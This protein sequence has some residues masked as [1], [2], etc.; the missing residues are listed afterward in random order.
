ME[1]V[2]HHAEIALKG[3]NR[4]FFEKKLC[5]NLEG[6]AKRKNLSCKARRDQ[7]RIRCS[8]D[9]KE[10]D[11]DAVFGKTFG[12]K[13][14]AVATRIERTEEA[15]LEEAQRRMKASEAKTVRFVTKRADKSF[16]LTSLDIN[17][18]LGEV[19]NKHAKK[20]DYSA[21]EYTLRTEVTKDAIYVY[22][23]KR[24]G[25]GGLPV[26]TAGKVLVLFSGGIDSA[27]AAYLAM[28]RGC[29]CDFLHLHA[30]RNNDDVLKTK[31]PRII[32]ALNDYQPRAVLHLSPYHEYQ[33]RTIGAIPQPLDLVAFKHLVLRIGQGLARKHGYKALV[34]GDSIGQ[35]ASQTLDNL[36]TQRYG[37]T[38]PILSPLITY[39]K[40]EIIDLTK[41]AGT[42]ELSIEEYKD[43][44]S[45]VS[46]K[47]D[48]HAKP[49][50]L[51]EALEK[52]GFE[53]VVKATVDATTSSSIPQTARP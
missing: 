33:L 10:S 20:V 2:V 32:E 47:P 49:E 28:K 38:A 19:A 31:I 25:L 37:I 52:S 5:E 8:F 9:G 14:Y 1:V 6:A 29:R 24:P 26:G 34:T 4:G 39:D 41:R 3:G 45:I 27:A 35:V 44:C 48:T 16:P 42:Y 22:D 17:K 40:Q 36:R 15:L 11:L 12:V 18:R 50:A 53:E 46:R 30:L 51:K 13:D 43:C 21:G 7:G 23:E